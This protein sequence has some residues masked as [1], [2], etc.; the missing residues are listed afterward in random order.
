MH[1]ME[2]NDGGDSGERPT[3]YPELEYHTPTQEQ[4]G[5][6]E[7]PPVGL[8]DAKEDPRKEVERWL[9]IFRHGSNN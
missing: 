2:G 7:Q 9:E 5:E 3:D 4:P 8:P 6:P 1:R